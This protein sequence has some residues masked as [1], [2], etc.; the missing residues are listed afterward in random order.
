IYYR[1]K[2]FLFK[3][4]IRFRSLSTCTVKCANKEL[5]QADQGADR[6]SVPR[7][8]L[9]IVEL[10]N[11][12][13]ESTARLDEA[14]EAV[15]HLE[16]SLKECND[17]IVDLEWELFGSNQLPFTQVDRQEHVR[18]LEARLADLYRQY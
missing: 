18:N 10:E 15:E 7:G 14:T 6:H 17:D 3:T 11:E 1:G 8:A 4:A 5:D 16:H 2:T 13:Q 9:G 12:L